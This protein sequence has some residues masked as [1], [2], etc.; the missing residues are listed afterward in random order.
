VVRGID[1]ARSGCAF[2]DDSLTV[3]AARDLLSCRDAHLVGAKHATATRGN[4]ARVGSPLAR[5]AANN[6]V[7]AELCGAQPWLPLSRHP[8]LTASLPVSAGNRSLERRS[9]ARGE[10][11]ADETREQS[12][13]LRSRGCGSPPRRRSPFR[14]APRTAAVLG[15]CLQRAARA[16]RRPPP[17]PPGCDVRAE[18]YNAVVPQADK[19]LARRCGGDNRPANRSFRR[20]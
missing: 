4:R 20:G 3:R 16:P 9:C 7:E 5:S 14:T 11:G 19:L 12:R 13:L 1:D 17:K 6:R 18:W 10:W 2:G 15:V 8:G